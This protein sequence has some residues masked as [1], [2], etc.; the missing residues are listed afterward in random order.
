[1][2]TPAFNTAVVVY[3][4]TQHDPASPT[5]P[6]A[7][8]YLMA[9]RGVDGAWASTYET[10]WAILS[11]TQVMK[12]SGELAGD[13]EFTAGLNGISLL[14]GSARGDAKLNPVNS[15]T[16][17]HSLYPQDPN[18]LI[19]QRGDGPGR[20]YYTAHL[21]VLRPVEDVTS[22]DQGI[23][24]SR[25]YETID[26]DILGEVDGDAAASLQF[27]AGEPVVVKV[28]IALKSAAYYLVIEDY[29]PAGAEI[30]DANLK[31]S[32]RI[33]AEY[34]PRDPFGAGWG[35]WY[36]NDPQ[37][38][39]ER[40]AWSVEYLPPGTYELTY[41]IILNQPGEYRVLP[42]RAWEFYFPEVQGN[43][44]GAVFTI[45]E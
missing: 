10:S 28:A 29:I 11:L 3:G 9:A 4:L 31:T 35:W 41:T 27:S 17:I 13:F 21:N 26:G 6:E 32:Q 30:L 19:L 20:L 14:E 25:A 12:T 7:V 38:Y 39:D 37:V 24:V 40:I 42:S 2:E 18:A 43:G 34:D 22:L 45:N 15:V 44:N 16:P 5:L 23:R 36:F 8:R 1:M 33:N